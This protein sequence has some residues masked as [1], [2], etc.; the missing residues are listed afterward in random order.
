MEPTTIKS[1][2]SGSYITIKNN[3]QALTTQGE[4]GK[5]HLWPTCWLLFSPCRGRPQLEMACLAIYESRGKG[6]LWCEVSYLS[7]GCVQI[8]QWNKQ[9]FTLEPAKDWRFFFKE[10]DF[11]IEFSTYKNLLGKLL[12]GAKQGGRIVCKRCMFKKVHD[13]R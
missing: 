13:G 2:T 1:L 8:L 7:A 3:C 9:H 5:I 6:N 12:V 10:Y 11:K 4:I